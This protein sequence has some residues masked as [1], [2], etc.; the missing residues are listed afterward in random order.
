MLRSLQTA[1]II[2]ALVTTGAT[3][4]HAAETAPNRTISVTGTGTVNARPDTA[5]ISIGVVSD[6]KTAR[7]ALDANTAAMTRVIAELKGQSIDPKDIQTSGFSVNPRYQHFKYGKP[8]VI[9]GY[10]VVNSATIVVRDLK[11]LGTILDLTVSQGSNQINGIQFSVD[12]I[13]ELENEARIRAM[14]DAKQKASLYAKAGDTKIGR[15]LTISE[16]GISR[17]PQPVY[18]SAARVAQASPVPVEAGEQKITARIH[19]LWEL[20][21]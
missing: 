21:D 9:I 18:R 13:T 4:I 12:D 2:L 7:E 3:G 6:S 1:A 15:V 8:A 11:K 19:V 20:S 10:R 14:K 5:Q 16:D 17:P